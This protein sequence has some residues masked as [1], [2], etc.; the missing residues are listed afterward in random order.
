MPVNWARYLNSSCSVPTS[1]SVLASYEFRVYHNTIKVSSSQQQ[2]YGYGPLSTNDRLVGFVREA[3]RVLFKRWRQRSA[4][5]V[6]CSEQM[7]LA[8]RSQAA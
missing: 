5:F 1:A 7:R 6:G 4:D 2:Q 8:Y 3:V